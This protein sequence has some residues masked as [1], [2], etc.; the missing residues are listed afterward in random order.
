VGPA[1]NLA[2]TVPNRKIELNQTDDV[3]ETLSGQSDTQVRGKNC[4]AK[5]AAG[6]P[7][8]TLR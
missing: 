4:P 1:V 6:E 3:L 2:E 5:T 7:L 8:L